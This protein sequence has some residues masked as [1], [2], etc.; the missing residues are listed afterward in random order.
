MQLQ[1]ASEQ[2]ASRSCTLDHVTEQS[3]AWIS[4]PR[5]VVAL[6]GTDAR[7]YLHGQISQDVQSLHVGE[8]RW[9]LVLAPN[10]RV[11]VLARVLCTAED[12][13]ELDTEVGYGDV[14]AT[15]LNRFRIRV[16]AELE[17]STVDL[18]A[19]VGDIGEFSVQ[20]SARSAHQSRVGWWETGRWVD[21]LPSGALIGT[22]DDYERARVAAGWPAMG[23]EIVPGE[24]IPAEIA[25]V[26]VA[27]DF[28]KGCY[29]G[30]ELVERMDARGSEAPRQL[31]LVAVEDGPQPGVEVTSVAGERA[32]AYVKRGVA[33]GDVPGPTSC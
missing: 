15:R 23:S 19:P 1:L 17:Q 16:K 33:V 6:V 18:F 32:L 14:L 22:N 11:E 31:R 10:G 4:V 30:Q 9:T 12:R 8:S 28:T 7:T 24:R 27:V 20:E 13:F 21:E 3:D 29:P 26:P 5:D 2:S 25:V